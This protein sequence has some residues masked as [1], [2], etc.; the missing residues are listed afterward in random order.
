MWKKKLNSCPIVEAFPGYWGD[1]YVK[2]QD[3]TS[4]WIRIGEV[5]DMN[6]NFIHEPTLTS[7]YK[8]GQWKTYRKGMRSWDI[9]LDD[10]LINSEVGQNFLRD[11]MMS[12]KRFFVKILPDSRY[13]LFGNRRYKWVGGAIVKNQKINSPT[14]GLTTDSYI[15]QGVT[16]LSKR[17]E[18]ETTADS[19]AV[20]C[21]ALHE[22]LYM[23]VGETFEAPPAPA[24]ST[25]WVVDMNF[26]AQTSGTGNIGT[27]TLLT[28]GPG[29]SGCP[30]QVTYRYL[31]ADQAFR[32][33]TGASFWEQF[34][35]IAENTA[36][37][38]QIA[39]LQEIQDVINLRL[40]QEIYPGVK[41]TAADIYYEFNFVFL[42]KNPDFI[43]DLS[44]LGLDDLILVNTF[45]NLTG[46]DVN[47]NFLTVFDL[48]ELD[49]PTLVYLDARFNLIGQD[50]I[51]L[52]SQAGSLVYLDLSYNFLNESY[53][54][55]S[56]GGGG[57]HTVEF[58]DLSYNYLA[59][60]TNDI[61]KIKVFKM[62]NNKFPSE[63]FLDPLIAQD[64][65]GVRLY[66][67]NSAVLILTGDTFKNLS[68]DL[69]INEIIDINGS[70]LGDGTIAGEDAEIA[71]LVAEL[72]IQQGISSAQ[73][74]GIIK[75]DNR[76]SS[77]APPEQYDRYNLP[78]TTPP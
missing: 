59:L 11:K 18:T 54:F 10:I 30:V 16:P 26:Q 37:P 53:V 22:T 78:R 24:G 60:V 21:D 12:G 58:F 28:T 47:N 73:A 6:V 7:L 50:N 66:D 44:G 2:E 5:T 23:S 35:E 29:N 46:L 4:S 67:A 39:I 52:N 9:S 57:S 49:G 17:Y 56:F 14:K 25:G 71:A 19:T 55:S 42:V 68:S 15:L 31:C 45:T 32:P 62:V 38:G 74:R 3:T 13:N 63:T 20:C 51:E 41:A 36:N 72:V 27:I 64:F 77:S 33:D 70:R 61:C 69:T 8:G 40:G 76:W 34:I 1:L 48:E 43:L 65:W 75:Y